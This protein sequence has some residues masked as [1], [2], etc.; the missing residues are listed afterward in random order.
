MVR[1]KSFGIGDESFG[2][3][4]ESHQMS[5]YKHNKIPTKS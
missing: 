3:G 2:I 4:L 5:F 1:A